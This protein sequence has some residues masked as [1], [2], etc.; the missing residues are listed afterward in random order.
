MKNI[1]IL[2][3]C[4]LMTLGVTGCD[5]TGIN[6]NPDKPTDD[7]NYNMNEPRLASTLRGGVIIDGNVEQRLKPLQL[8][9]YSQM[10]NDGGGWSTKNYIQN[11]EWNNLTWEEY[12]KQIASINIV[13]RSLTEKDKDAYANTIAFAKIWRVYVHTLAADKFGPMP[14]PAYETAEANPPYKSLKDI[15]DE[16]F[17]ELD[18][19]INGFSDS[20]QPIFSDSGIDLV[21]KN[22]VSK[23]KRFANSLRLRLAVRLTEVDREKC[24]TEANAAISSPAGLI[25]DRVDNA[26]MPPKADGSWGQDYNYVMF[27][28]TWSGP[29]C[30]SKSVEKLFNNIGGIAWPEGVVNQTS[31]VP[32]SSVHP[33]KVDP[34][35]PKIFQPGIE[36]GDWKGLVYGPKAEEANTGVYQSKQCAELGFIIKDGAPYKSRPYDLFLSEEVHFLKAELYARGFIAGDAKSEYEAGVRA[37]FTT[38]GIASE[39]DAYLASTEKN[40]AGTSAKYDDQQGDGNTALEKII[41]QKYIAGIPDLAQE[42]WS[43]KRRLNLPRLDVAVYRDEAV[44]NNKDMNILNPQNFIKRMKYP[45]KEKLIN[46]AEY[47]KGKSMLGGKGDIVSSPLW[48]DKNSNYCTSS[49]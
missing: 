19:A 49:K 10:T 33:E 40:D 22:D 25:V 35:A 6:E 15:Y 16:Y 11:D 38:W 3:V 34:R 9:F 7:V 20:A 37:S 41:T 29:I 44:Y 2:A 26:Y 47:E 1:K 5:L 18:A 14:F 31:G 27:Q 28:I 21:Y 32:V 30:M 23:W 45:T 36:N 42:A 39:V 13:I 48:W 4:S 17:T 46:A 24:I 12:L 8:D 43:D